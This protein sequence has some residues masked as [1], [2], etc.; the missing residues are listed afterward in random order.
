VDLQQDRRSGRLFP[1]VEH[2]QLEPP[3]AG[4][5]RQAPAPVDVDIGHAER[6][7]QRLPGG[8]EVVGQR[9]PLDDRAV[10]GAELV[11]ERALDRCPGPPGARDKGGV[12]GHVR[13]GDGRPGGV[14]A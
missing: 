5:I 9:I 14:T 2:V 12:P 6:Q 1:V 3:P 10:V 13:G 4:R 8:L 7:G 11:D